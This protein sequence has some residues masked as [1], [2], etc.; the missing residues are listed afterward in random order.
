MIGPG[1]PDIGIFRHILA[2]RIRKVGL[3]RGALPLKRIWHASCKANDDRIGIGPIA[4]N[5]RQK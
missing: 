5:G 3:A 1:Q 4:K 2:P